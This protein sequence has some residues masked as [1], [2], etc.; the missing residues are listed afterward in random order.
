[1]GADF[2]NVSTGH[3]WGFVQNREWSEWMMS[4]VADIALRNTTDICLNDVHVYILGTPT[5]SI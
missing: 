3:T 2:L 1:M 4:F 5:C